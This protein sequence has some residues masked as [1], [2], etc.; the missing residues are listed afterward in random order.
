MWARAKQLTSE[1]PVARQKP[2]EVH[3]FRIYLLLL[4]ECCSCLVFASCAFR[5]Q[6]CFAA[7]LGVWV[8]G[9]S[10]AS[11]VHVQLLEPV[12]GNGWINTT[13]HPPSQALIC[14]ARPRLRRVEKLQAEANS[15]TQGVLQVLAAA[16][17]REQPSGA[18]SAFGVPAEAPRSWRVSEPRGLRAAACRGALRNSP[19][20]AAPSGPSP[21]AARPRPGLGSTAPC[22][23]PGA[24]GF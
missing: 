16:Q 17:R 14:I 11:K 21:G 8:V 18:L 23:A 7:R 9:V 15:R 4:G 13:H 1:A 12:V 20:G 6:P 22:S 5:V 3:P 10:E 19:S 24:S 2:A